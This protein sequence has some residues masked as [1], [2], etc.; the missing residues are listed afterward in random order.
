[1]LL[2][3]FAPREATAPCL[4][5]IRRRFR[6]LSVGNDRERPDAQAYR[7]YL[8][9]HLHYLGGMDQH[10][11]RMDDPHE[12]PLLGRLPGNKAEH[13]GVRRTHAHLRDRGR[14]YPAAR[15]EKGALVG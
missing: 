4:R 5:A 7:I 14:R 12:R 3:R 11:T 9:P 8:L 10:S 13:G 15:V 1:M 6:L 2:R